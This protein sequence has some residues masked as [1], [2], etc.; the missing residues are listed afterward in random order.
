[1]AK[2]LKGIENIDITFTYKGK[3]YFAPVVDSMFLKDMSVGEIKDN[4]NEIPARA[5]YWKT[6]LVSLERSIEEKEEDFEIWFQQKYMDV[7]TEYGK[8]TE[9]FKKSKVMLENVDEYRKMKSGLRD[10]KDIT[11]KINILV[12]G[13]NTKTWT[14]R[15]IARL[16]YAEISGLSASSLKSKGSLSDF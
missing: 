11:K 6:F 12:S 15:E 1:M 9:G 3:K 16:T 4:L 14:L 2:S 8:K 7:D 5:S 13:Y 10:L